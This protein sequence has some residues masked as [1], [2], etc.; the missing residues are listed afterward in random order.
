MHKQTKWQ[1][2]LCLYDDRRQ[3]YFGTTRH[4]GAKPIYERPMDLWIFTTWR[5]SNNYHLIFHFFVLYPWRQLNNIALFIKMQ[6][7]TNGTF[8][9]KILFVF[10]PLPYITKLHSLYYAKNR[11]TFNCKGKLIFISINIVFWNIYE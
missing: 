5:G 6:V 9:Y 10:F 11:I 7:H 2:I 3:M 4:S 8:I 1:N